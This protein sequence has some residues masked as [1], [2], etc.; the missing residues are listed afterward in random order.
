[1]LFDMVKSA[2]GLFVPAHIDKLKNSLIAQLGFIPF[3]LEYDA[4][5][6]SEHGHKDE[7]LKIHKYLK[8]KTFTRSSDA[9]IPDR[10]GISPC[11]L[12]LET[13]SFEEIAMAFHQ[14]EGR[15]VMLDMPEEN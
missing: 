9:H 1:M 4:V 11:Y 7:I 2:G 14:Q 15:M 10:V 12:R 3:D 6:L 8:N 13:R 5:E